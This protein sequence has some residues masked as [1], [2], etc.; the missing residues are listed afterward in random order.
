MLVIK[1]RE[2]Y[3]AEIKWV[4]SRLSLSYNNNKMVQKKGPGAENLTSKD[5]YQKNKSHLINSVQK[6]T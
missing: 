1:L 6:N 2:Y 4:T 5:S 3:R